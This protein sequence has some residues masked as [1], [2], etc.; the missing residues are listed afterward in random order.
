MLHVSWPYLLKNK[1]KVLQK[2][3]YQDS[4]QNVIDASL[5]CKC[6]S[7][8]DQRGL[9][10]ERNGTSD[11]NFSLR[12]YV[13]C[14]SESGIGM[15]PWASPDTSSMIIRTQLEARFVAKH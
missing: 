5:C 9:A 4:S 1:A 12:D 7:N 2:K 15:L 10:I 14:N 13:A 11:H 3:R 8:D 6:A